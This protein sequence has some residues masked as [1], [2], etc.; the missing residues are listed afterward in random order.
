MSW[1]AHADLDDI[2]ALIT[3]LTGRTIRRVVA[4][5]PEWTATLIDHG[6]PAFQA[7]ML[8]DMVQ[9]ARRGEFATTGKDLETLIGA[10]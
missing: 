8:L 9:A 5:D 10:L 6:M 2:A 1:T 4:E 7:T 3:D